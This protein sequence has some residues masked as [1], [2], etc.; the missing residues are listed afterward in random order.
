MCLSAAWNTEGLDTE[1][2]IKP[3][4]VLVCN[5][6]FAHSVSAF[7]SKSALLIKQIPKT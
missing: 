7:I 1:S 5:K 3:N 6:M 4:G 2:V